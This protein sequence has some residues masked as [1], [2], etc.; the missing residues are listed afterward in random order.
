MSRLYLKA[1]CVGGS[2]KW[3]DT[4]RRIVGVDTAARWKRD[5]HDSHD[6][7]TASRYGYRKPMAVHDHNR[8]N[9]QVSQQRTVF[10]GEWTSATTSLTVG[11]L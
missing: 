2:R 9:K 3:I 5:A 6:L 1:E 4:D 8:V 11:L 7:R 10:R